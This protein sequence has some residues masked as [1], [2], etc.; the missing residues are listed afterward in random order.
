M[1]LKLVANVILILAIIVLIHM[2]I[3]KY[4]YSTLLANENFLNNFHRTP[5]Y[6]PIND[7]EHN[8]KMSD[9]NVTNNDIHNKTDIR[10]PLNKNIDVNALIIEE[11]IRKEKDLSKQQ[12]FEGINY[13]EFGDDSELLNFVKSKDEVHDT[14]ISDDHLLEPYD[15]SLEIVNY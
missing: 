1:T 12:D 3:N 11:N 9:I 4:I 7:I 2:L 13:E 14:M 15:G 10:K 8:N 5:L 6:E